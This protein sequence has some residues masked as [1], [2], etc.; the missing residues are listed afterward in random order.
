MPRR[1]SFAVSECS[2]RRS[3]AVRLCLALLLLLGTGCGQKPTPPAPVPDALPKARQALSDGDF[4]GAQELA[5]SIPRSSPDW[6]AA[7][8]LAGE[9]ALKAGDHEQSLRQYLLL[10]EESDQP[11]LAAEGLY[12]AAELY[13]DLGR[14]QD[15]VRSYQKV[16]QV[17][18]ENA[19]THE[20]L[21]LLLSTCGRN[22][23]ARPHFWFLIK[24]GSARLQ[25]LSLFADLDRSS[26]QR[27]F[28]EGCLTKSPD[29]PLVQLGLA[30]HDYWDGHTAAAIERLEPLLEQHPDFIVG[31]AII[32]EALVGGPQ[33]Q[34]LDWDREL[35]AGADQH[36]DI[37]YVRG[38][39]ARQHAQLKVAARC[40]WETLRHAP[41]HRR[42]T[43]QLGQILTSLE[44]PGSEAFR[45]RADQL[46]RLTQT[47]DAVLRSRGQKEEPMRQTA[48]LLEQMGRIWEACGWA[49]V[50]R[51]QFAE[52]DW[53]GP[54]FARLTPLLTDDL[55]ITRLEDDLSVRFDLTDYPSFDQLA[56]PPSRSPRSDE[57][58]SGAVPTISF[59]EQPLPFV[60]YNAA[61][62]Q[63]QGARQFEQTGGGVGVLDFDADG[64]S[65]LFLTQG[66]EWI[67]NESSPTPSGQ[68]RDRLF[69]SAAGRSLDI[70]ESALPDDPGYGQGCAAG[71]FD[72]DGFCDLYVANVG[73]NQ[74][75][76]NM[77]DGTFVD[78]T[79]D[80]KLPRSDWTTSVLMADLNDD[81]LPDLFDVNYLQGQE[82]FTR[83]CDGLA[84][85][86]SVFPAAPDQLWI[87]RGDG[88]FEPGGIEER[89][90]DSKGLGV[91]GL[92]VGDDT[93]LSLFIANDQ[94]ANFLLRNL[95]SDN[96][97]RIRLVDEAFITGLAFNDD[98]LAMACMGVAADDADNDG[99]TDLFVTNFS[100]EANT[101][102]LQDA[103]GLFV[104]ASNVANLE[105][106]SYPYVGWG[107][108]FLDAD[109]D[110][111]P[112]LVLTN[113]HV[114]DFTASG[115]EYHMRPQFFVNRGG[116]R[117][118]ELFADTL[119]NYFAGT[120]LGRGLARLDWNQDGLMDFVV[121]HIGVPASL[122]T[123][124]TQSS[125]RHYLN[126]RLHA[127]TTARDAINT[128]VV[129]TAEGRTWTKTLLAGD[130]YQASNERMLQFGLGDIDGGVEVLIRW[131]SGAITHLSG[132]PVDGA[133]EVVEG[134]AAATRWEGGKPTAYRV[135]PQPT[136]GDP[137]R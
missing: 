49:L 32:G 67:T 53:P 7:R 61:D 133:Y 137:A 66:C 50:V 52:S 104:D 36:P 68:Y 18:P 108:Q 89:V 54:L 115:Q 69:R 79:A 73:R 34:F 19:A 26:D 134:R 125:G 117:F 15:A 119:G 65:D 77:G 81:G 130:G 41:S 132:P 127:S 30:V 92:P 84:C 62:P 45:E 121:S 48:E 120:Y 99:L 105:A 75:L 80:A 38:L 4:A 72:N 47:I 43:Y 88:A 22:W 96:P 24:S 2:A 90:H 59:S 98:G 42:A 126:F 8:L 21:A 76:R 63:T 11:R 12:Y 35:P 10:A 33:A 74:L 71:D 131:P 6:D 13:R 116:G 97:Q 102:Y 55:P 114:D 44:V 9:A 29:D 101:L 82:V 57:P 136:V 25:E 28:L 27:A 37:W 60:Y 123:N 64:R 91:V 112:D 85:S 58:S 124:Q 23:E 86:P 93:R 109:L 78:V 46:I 129:V 122:V 118:E 87:S 16:L 128:Q 95:P 106:A 51:Q 39:W 5:G 111:R 17:L 40:F 14:L 1:G 103:S 3:D 113:G 107:T 135:D 83:V 20:R 31:Q 56:A 100:N 94:V 70:T 110:G